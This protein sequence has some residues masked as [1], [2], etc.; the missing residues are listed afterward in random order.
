MAVKLTI[1]ALIHF[2]GS[3]ALAENLP[4]IPDAILTVGVA[5]NSEPLQ[6]VEWLLA[7]SNASDIQFPIWA[8]TPLQLLRTTDGVAYVQTLVM[9]VPDSWTNKAAAFTTNQLVRGWIETNK[10]VLVTTDDWSKYFDPEPILFLFSA[11]QAGEANGEPG[12]AS[13]TSPKTPP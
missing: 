9:A 7:D 12:A 6:Q 8:G 5:S 4:H 13:A 1:I 2:V 10:L 11:Q 3:I